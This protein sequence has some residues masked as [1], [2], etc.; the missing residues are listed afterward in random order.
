MPLN[1]NSDAV[2]SSKIP[3]GYVDIRVFAHATE[4]VDKVLDAV[5]NILSPELIDIVAF[6]KTNLTGHHGNP[7]ILFETRIKEKNAAKKVFEKLS[8]GLSTVDKELLNSEINQHLDKGNLYIRLDKQ[9][10]YLNE[11]K[12]SSE[13]PIHFR[14]H[15]KKH[16]QEEVID[17][18]RKFGLLP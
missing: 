11:L 2:L 12:L 1:R 4:E 9:S 16:S 3:I 6:K 13:D 10:A 15:F 5:R 8:L 7:I 18:C 17:I 14:I